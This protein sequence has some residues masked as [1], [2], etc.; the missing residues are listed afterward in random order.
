[1][2]IN[3][4]PNRDTMAFLR[5]D[6]TVYKQV[7]ERGRKKKEDDKVKWMV[8]GGLILALF[9]LFKV[10]YRPK[11]PIFTSGNIEE[12]ESDQ[13]LLTKMLITPPKNVEETAQG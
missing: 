1:M 3:G 2:S 5:N 9:V 7:P 13:N 12:V 6:F 11:M 4:E 10:E 8:A